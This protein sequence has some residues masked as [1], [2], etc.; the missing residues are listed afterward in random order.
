MI[1]FNG[2]ERMHENN[3]VEALCHH[4][5]H[6]YHRPLLF[7]QVKK[8]QTLVDCLFSHN[9][10]NKDNRNDINEYICELLIDKN[11][12]NA[13]STKWTNINADGVLC[14]KRFCILLLLL[15]TFTTNSMALVNNV[16]SPPTNDR[17]ENCIP[18]HSGTSSGSALNLH[19]HSITKRGLF[20]SYNI[21]PSGNLFSPFTTG[22]T[23]PGTSIVSAN[24]TYFE[25]PDP[26]IYFSHMVINETL[27]FVYIG[28]VNNIY[29]LNLRLQLLE[30][31]SMGP[32]E[33]S[34]ECLISKGCMPNVA[35]PL[36]NY[37]NK[38]LVVDPLHQWLISCGSLFQ[39][40]CTAHS[41]HN[42]TNLVD[43]PIESVV[44]NNATA[45]TVAF[46]APGPDP[47]KQVLYVGATF[48]AGSYRS[49]LPIVSS[50]SLFENSKYWQ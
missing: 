46:I 15:S 39:G 44:A 50:R 49:D 18:L 26:E 20:D 11:G 41:L 8:R 43:Q 4:H 31:I 32:H 21:F 45:S 28:A 42:V 47:H 48:T 23:M 36:S 7:D 6:H 19:N 1:E 29:Q 34:N 27:G 2:E 40:T 38:A 9:N 13:K 3:E 30:R 37:Y 12:H 35:K 33:D 16:R 14:I 24:L 25:E 22:S 17:S 5:A 10:N